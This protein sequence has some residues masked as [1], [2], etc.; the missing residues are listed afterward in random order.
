M[1]NGIRTEEY[2]KINGILFPYREVTFHN[3]QKGSEIT[4]EK[5]ELNIE[6]PEGIFDIPEEVKAIMDK[7]ETEPLAQ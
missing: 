2:K 7:N 4:S 3:G 1:K 5:I 6:M